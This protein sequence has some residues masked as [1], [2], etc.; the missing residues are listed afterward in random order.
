[1]NVSASQSG[2][3]AIVYVCTCFAPDC[4][5][6]VC[7]CAIFAHSYEITFIMKIGIRTLSCG[8]F[9]ITENQVALSQQEIDINWI[10]ILVN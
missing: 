5:V 1:M 6:V 3:L 7:V 8:I 2:R 4:L 10:E 9:F